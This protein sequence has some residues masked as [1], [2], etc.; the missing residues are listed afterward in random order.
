M[1][2]RP[3]VGLANGRREVFRSE[4]TPTAESH[5][6][7]DAVTGPFRTVKAARLAAAPH[8]P[9]MQSVSDF[10]RVARKNPR[11]KIGE[12]AYCARCGQDVEWNDGWRDRGGNRS[13]VPFIRNGEVIRPTGK[14]T[15]KESSPMKLNPKRRKRKFSRKQ[16]AAQKR[17][18]KMAKARARERKVSYQEYMRPLKR[19][20]GSRVVV[21]AGGEEFFRTNPKLRERSQT[22][23]AQ[24]LREA[25]KEWPMSTPH[26]KRGITKLIRAKWRGLSPDYRKRHSGVKKNPKRKLGTIKT[27]VCYG[28]KNGKKYY[29]QRG[30]VSAPVFV[31]DKHKAQGYR[32]DRLALM[33]IKKY[34]RVLARSGCTHIGSEPR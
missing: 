9:T 15:V 6:Q 31:S 26:Q 4:R 3:Y 1:S 16:L 19:G 23:A 8:G 17:F 20:Q 21:G 33:T 25:R 32:T 11:R 12:R 14:H 34:R 18:A 24:F 28:V 30:P 2:S 10:E 22:A 27:F 13:C 29:L 5:G 7:Y